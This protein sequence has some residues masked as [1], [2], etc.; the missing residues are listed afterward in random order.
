VY[1]L[2][3]NY[4]FYADVY[5]IQNLI[6]KAGVLYMTF[7]CNRIHLCISTVL[8]LGKIV[9][10]AGLGTVIEILGLMAGNSYNVFLLLV[11]VL[12]IPLMIY[13]LCGKERVQLLRTIITGYFFVIVINGILELLWNW[14]GEHGNYVF[15]LCM[16]CGFVYV[17]TRIW[18]NYNRIQK[19]IFQVEIKHK[20]RMVSTYGLYDSGNQLTDPYTQKGVHII[21]EQLIKKLGV[22]KEEDEIEETASAYIPYQALGNENGIIKVYYIDELFI[23]GETQKIRVEKCPL[24]VT[25]ENLFK[26]QKY[27]MILNEEVF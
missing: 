13:L 5:F 15:Y 8:G 22:L 25:K 20:E 18:Q 19:G 24:G 21:S 17:G 12:E 14:F 9:L 2:T 11:H 26:E 6:I 10:V 27:E 23:A 16:A 1:V 3:K 7:Y 4:I